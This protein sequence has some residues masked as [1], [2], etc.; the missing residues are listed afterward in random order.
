MVFLVW[1]KVLP[2]PDDTTQGESTNKS[3][4]ETGKPTDK[5]KSGSAQEGGAA[6]ETVLWIDN[7]R[8]R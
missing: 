7:P 8:S 1:R 5:S 3:E 6:T 2:Q 4:D